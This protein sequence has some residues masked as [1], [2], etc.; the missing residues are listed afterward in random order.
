VNF[1]DSSAFLPLMVKETN[2]HEAR[3]ILEEKPDPVIWWATPIECVS[4]LARKEREGVL[5]FTAMKSAIHLLDR[6]V[7]HAICVDASEPV[8]REARRLL[9]R[10]PLRAADS[11]QLA[12]ALLF[13]DG[14]PE[15]H[16]FVCNDERLC[17]AA[18]KEGFEV[19]IP[20]PPP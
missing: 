14:N 3:K 12:A 17:E 11:M 8:R 15:M 19:I 4:A 10:H 20:I 1:W 6:I 9:R 5:D 16:G 2:S 13:A 7:S 18:A